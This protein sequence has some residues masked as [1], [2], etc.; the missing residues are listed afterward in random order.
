MNTAPTGK[1]HMARRAR[2]QAARTE[3]AAG[4]KARAALTNKPGT[5]KKPR[6]TRA[7]VTCDF[8]RRNALLCRARQARGT[9][10]DELIKQASAIAPLTTREMNACR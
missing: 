9:E 7:G 10:R 5:N 2:A 8:G 6:G 3:D 4:R 1:A